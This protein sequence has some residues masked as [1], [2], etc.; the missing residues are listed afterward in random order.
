MNT[1]SGL[2]LHRFHWLENEDLIGEIPQKWN[3]LVDYNDPVPVNELGI[4][5]YTE[6]GPYFEDYRN[7]G[8]AEEWRHEL[9]DLL[10]PPQPA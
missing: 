7:C 1:K 5:H 4:L 3:H 10:S 6:G 2:E 9:R 8:Y